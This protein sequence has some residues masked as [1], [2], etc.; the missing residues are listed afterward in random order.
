MDRPSRII[1]Q[2]ESDDDM[3]QE[4]RVGGEVVMVIEGTITI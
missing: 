2:V 4:V 3:I 1:I